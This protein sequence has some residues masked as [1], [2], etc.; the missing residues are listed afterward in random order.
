MLRSALPSKKYLKK[1]G[2]TET[3]FWHTTRADVRHLQGNI[4]PSS[5]PAVIKINTLQ[6]MYSEDMFKPPELPYYF[7]TKAK[8]KDAAL[9]QIQHTEGL[10][11]VW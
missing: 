3:E 11:G 7:I 9:V 5:V 1:A 8:Q 10:L 4:G 2:S 6:A